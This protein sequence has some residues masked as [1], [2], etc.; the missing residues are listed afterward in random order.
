MALDFVKFQRGTQS[1]YNAIK[2]SNPSRIDENTL[3][4]IYDK[5]NPNDNGLLYLGSTLI[6]GMGVSGVT[7]LNNL[8]DVNISNT[9]TPGMILQYNNSSQ[10]WEPISIK[11]AI[12]NSGASL[13]SGSITLPIVESVIKANNESIGVALARIDPSPTEGD[14]VFVN[15]NPYIYDGSM[16]KELIGTAISTEINNLKERVSTAESNI[17]NLQSIVSTANHLSYVVQNSLTPIT[18]SNVGTLKNTVFL[19]PNGNTSGNNQYDEYMVVNNSYEK[20]GSWGVNL[21]N[22]V[23]SSTFDTTVNNL[24]DAISSIR[25]N[26]DNCVLTSTFDTTI[27]NLYDAINNINTTGNLDNYVLKTIYSAEVGDLSILANSVN[28]ESTSIV[29]EIIDINDRLQWHDIPQV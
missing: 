23:L 16:W 21:D 20:L 15:G 29:E 2:N 19:V 18:E 4:F 28:K 26:L 12:E 10:K 27:N 9:L 24:E 3:Y 1:A 25:N 5:S 17:I 22:Y 8:T 6:G 7:E 11:T 14:I 13:N